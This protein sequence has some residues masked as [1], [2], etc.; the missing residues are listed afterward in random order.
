MGPVEWARLDERRR[1]NITKVFHII[2]PI[3]N[4]L[5]PISHYYEYSMHGM[6]GNAL[7]TCHPTPSPPPNASR[8]TQSRKIA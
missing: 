7:F 3:A 6:F 1:D 4:Y 8:R 5:G 2:L